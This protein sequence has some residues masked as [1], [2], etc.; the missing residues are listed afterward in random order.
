MG[1]TQRT[2]YVGKKLRPS[3]IEKLEKVGFRWI[4]REDLWD[5]YFK[6]LLEYGKENGHYNVPEE[7]D[8]NPKLGIWVRNQ[9]AAFRAG[10]L[11]S[12]RISLLNGVG[13]VWNPAAEAWKAYF[14]LLQDY[15]VQNGTTKVPV[16]LTVNEVPLG[17]WL[18]YQRRSL[19]KGTL[20]KWKADLLK[21]IGFR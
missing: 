4:P 3:R 11:S 15:V 6:L 20:P 17:Q 8:P 21:S 14:S 5:S 16:D 19:T 2:W 12:E 1:K 13:F 9:R 7:Y 10:I 18:R